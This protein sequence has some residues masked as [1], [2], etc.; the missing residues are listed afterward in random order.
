M[1]E[2]VHAG[3]VRG[4]FW[5]L[6]S[7]ILCWKWSEE[8]VGWQG[9]TLKGHAGSNVIAVAIS[10]DEKL[11]VSGASDNLVKIWNAKTGAEVHNP[12]GALGVD[13][14]LGGFLR[15]FHRGCLVDAV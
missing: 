2:C 12:G 9:Y 15:W 8:T 3:E 4:G 6:F 5:L 10:P 1:C 7:G 11:V 14:R 13:W